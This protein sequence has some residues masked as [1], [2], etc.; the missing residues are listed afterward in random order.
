MSD[1]LPHPPKAVLFDWDNTL[2]DSWG[3]I[4]TALNMTF[5]EFGL[6]R[7]SIAET[8][9]RVAR[10]MRD[11][12]PVLFGEDRWLDA[13]DSFY[14]HFQS[15]HLQTLQPLAGAHDLLCALRDNGT[16]IGVVSNK[17]GDFLRKEVDH[18]GW[19]PLFGQIVGATDAEKDKPAPDP[20]HM[21]MGD[22]SAP[23]YENLWF[24]GDSA[25]DIECA[26]NVGATAI[27]IGDEIT[28][29]SDTQ[30]SATLSPDWHFADCGALVRVVK[31]FSNVL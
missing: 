26:R 17:N 25:V 24:V 2:V 31:S 4:Q 1:Q 12:F 23:Q 8:K 7:W 20:V 27:L 29:H 21:A 22:S 5:E 16:Y 11:S 15:I 3:T 19:T 14:G 28:G 30:N 6:E 18:L 10:S 13:K 9:Q